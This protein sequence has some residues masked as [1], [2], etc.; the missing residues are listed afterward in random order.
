M[1]HMNLGRHI[2]EF[3]DRLERNRA[4]LPELLTRLSEILAERIE[5][6]EQPQADNIAALLQHLRTE[7]RSR[8]MLRKACGESGRWC[9]MCPFGA[10]IPAEFDFSS[11]TQAVCLPWIALVGYNVQ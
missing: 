11:E 1:I 4:A 2:A 9:K 10:F 8:E 7:I 3:L 6:I 5:E